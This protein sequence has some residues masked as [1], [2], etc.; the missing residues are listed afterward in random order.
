MV[1]TLARFESPGFL[2]VRTP[3]KPCVAAPVDKEE[4]L[5]HRVVDACQTIRTYPGLFERM[6]RSVMRRVEASIVSRG[7]RFEHSF[8]C[9]SQAKRFRTL[10]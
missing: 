1:S 3:E 2:P 8:R 10:Y 9:N 7:G 4:A 6:R 5:H